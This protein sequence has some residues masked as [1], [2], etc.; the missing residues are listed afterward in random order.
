MRIYWWQ[1]GVH[2]D[3]GTDE[4]RKALGV[5]VRSLDTLDLVKDSLTSRPVRGVETGNK[6]EVVL[7]HDV[8]D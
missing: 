8:P 1:A 6:E 5:L 2:I 3:P 4:E 7:G